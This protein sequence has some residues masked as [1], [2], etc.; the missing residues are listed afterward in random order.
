MKIQK[1]MQKRLGYS[2]AE[3]MQF[4]A[5]PRNA[6]VISKAAG[7]ADQRI[8]LKVVESAGR[9]ALMWGCSVAGGGASF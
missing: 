4:K 7:L 9:A 5:N 8:V 6:D 2:D 1:V 3:M